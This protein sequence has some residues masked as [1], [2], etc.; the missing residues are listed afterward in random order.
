[1]AISADGMTMLT[2]SNDK[3]ALLW[4]IQSMEILKVGWISILSPWCCVCVR[5]HHAC[6]HLPFVF[7]D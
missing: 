1:M 5:V 3:T 7:D 2:A 4:D 6:A